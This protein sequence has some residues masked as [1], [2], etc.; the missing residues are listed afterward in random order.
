MRRLFEAA[1]VDFVQWRALMRAYIWMDYGSLLGANGSK[2]AWQAT[3]QFVIM[4]GFM[5]LLGLGLGVVVWG[6][7]DPFFAA[8]LVVAALMMWAGLMVVTQP[9]SLAS[10]YDHEIIG[11]RPVTSRTYFAVRVTAMLVL[12]LE[13]TVFMGWVPVVAFATRRGGSL[14]LALAAGLA[15][16][17]AAV[18][19]ATGVVSIYGWLIRL[20]PPARLTRILSYTGTV[21]SLALTAAYL[22]GLSVLVDSEQPT[23]FLK[24]VLPRDVRTYWFP[25]AWFAS[26][27]AIAQGRFGTPDVLA[28]GASGITLLLFASALTGRMSLHY[29]ERVAQLA[30]MPAR[31]RAPR[32]ERRWFF[33]TREA[34]A[35]AI[36]V[37]S[38]LRGDPKFQLALASNVMMGLIIV[39]TGSGFE[40]PVDPF[41][42]TSRERAGGLTMPILALVMVPMHVYQTIASTT[43]DDASW[44]YFTTPANRPRI[45]TAGRD[46]VAL[47]VLLPLVLALGG[48][49][50][51]VYRHPVHAMAHCLF[52]GVFAVLSL[53]ANVFLKPQLPFSVPMLRNQRA[54]F[55]IG[56]LLLMM[57]VM[58]PLALVA[59]HFA[60]RS[61]TAMAVVVLVLLALS[62]G[63]NGLTRRRIAGHGQTRTTRTTR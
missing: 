6:A 54:P 5:T 39:V 12:V 52:L 58:T 42:A 10:P 51:W 11:A 30:T 63:L 50:A 24:T 23:N 1:G 46:V 61:W 41:T 62:A 56:T 2:E 14:A 40:L 18:A 35:V 17:G 21:I 19:T 8:V 57:L 25:G 48:F 34:R 55:S 22:A 26:Y 38:H 43:Q 37:V 4:F 28:A 36:L 20:I 31:Q 9:A 33:R 3:T 47:Y 16:V 15:F 29:A 27:V 59:Q 60:F 45:I 13:T 32:F 7:R 49:Y 53:Q 44:L